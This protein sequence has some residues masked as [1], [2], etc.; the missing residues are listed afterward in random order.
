MRQN[1]RLMLAFVLA[2]ALPAA[3]AM[4]NVDG[5]FDE[6]FDPPF[7][8]TTYSFGRPG[9][10]LWDYAWDLGGS[11][12]S[13]DRDRSAAVAAQAD[14]RILVAGQAWNAY[15]G[16]SQYA[17]TLLRVRPDGAAD[18]SFGPSADG[19]LI[20]NFNG[21]PVDCNATFVRTIG[22]GRI[23]WGGTITY[24][25]GTT[26]AWLQRLTRAGYDDLSFG[27]NGNSYF[28]GNANTSLSALAIDSDGTLYAA[29]SMIVVNA[30]DRDFHLL[31]LDADG[32]FL[33]SRSAAFDAGGN[34]DDWASALVIE[35][36]PG[37][38]CGQGCFISA[39]EEI[40]LVGTVT[41][42]PYV[43][44]SNRNCGVFA[45]RRALFDAEF[46]A[47]AN[48]GPDG[49][50]R[51]DIEFVAGGTN[52]GDNFCNAALARPGSGYEQVGYGV[53]VGGENYFISSLGGGSP[54]LASTFALAEV[55]GAGTVTRKDAFAYYQALPVPGVYNSIRSMSRQPD[56]RL[57][58]GGRAG[59]T[60]TG[61]AP[62]DSGV[63]R[64]NT[65]FTRDATF[66]NDG[67]GLTVASLDLSET[68]V[69][70]E[71][72]GALALDNRG[73]IVIAGNL[74]GQVSG[75]GAID[76]WT[77]ARLLGGD[78]IFR[79]GLDGIVPD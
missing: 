42:A 35:D 29:G 15:G 54:G 50:G 2:A 37:T 34:L 63:I 49:N 5:S 19:R 74:A 9:G 56:G 70:D 51:L 62:A 36:I 16:V 17:C 60:D 58:V 76:D 4:A 13:T 57:V 72:A 7:G 38:S 18:A 59:T 14:G 44:L 66:G 20:K 25:S 30:S 6:A 1:H 65:D 31:A 41:H 26:F 75:V 3:S 21:G 8:D 46:S 71:S 73:R 69:A 45:L 52:A 10:G 47:D 12:P 64:F 40:Y 68:V 33:Y 43:D 28:V 24:P 79:D 39:H 11:A 23:V 48:F 27:G 78:V 77:L 55:T 67:L 32:H 61:H 53:V 22:D